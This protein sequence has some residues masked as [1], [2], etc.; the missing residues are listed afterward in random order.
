MD[1]QY[2][3]LYKDEHLLISW[4]ENEVVSTEQ[5]VFLG[6]P[7]CVVLPFVPGAIRMQMS[8]CPPEQISETHAEG[9]SCDQRKRRTSMLT[10]WPFGHSDTSC[11][12]FIS[13]T[14][15]RARQH[16]TMKHVNHNQTNFR[17]FHTSL[18]SAPFSSE[19]CCIIVIERGHLRANS[20]WYE[21]KREG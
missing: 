18:W 8:G 3:D 15:S 20:Q 4:A 21:P 7:D 17:V 19:R 9:S 10:Y 12:H 6:I 5:I 11:E 2:N 16:F 1:M 14:A 13:K